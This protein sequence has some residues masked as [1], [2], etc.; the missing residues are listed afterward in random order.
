MTTTHYLLDGGNVIGEVEGDAATTYLRGVN[1]I[2]SGGT[3]YLYNAHGDVVQ[4][5]NTNG[6]LTRNYNYDAFGNERDPDEDDINPFRYCGEYYDTE[7]GLYYLRARYYDPLIGRFTQEDTHWNTANMI[8]GDNP[9]KI[10]EREDALGLKCYS[11]APQLL[12]IL[13]AGNLYVYTA[14]NPVRYADPSGALIWPGEIHQAVVTYIVNNYEGYNF[15]TEQWIQYSIP[16]TKNGK[17]YL[18]GRADI[19]SVNNSE[20]K[21]WE[22]KPDK[23]IYLILGAIQLSNYISGS[24][25]N[26]QDITLTEGDALNNA[27]FLYVD[28][29][30][31]MYWVK[32]RCCGGLILYTYEK[33]EGHPELKIVY[34]KRV[35]MSL[36]LGSAMF[37]AAAILGAESRKKQNAAQ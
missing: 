16:I 8:Y 7:T 22:V 29:T 32:F 30:G 15:Y 1:L 28:E 14:S 18:K 20:G 19:I 33:R 3:Y 35:A 27:E 24:L 2:S 17:V 26:F 25:V 21:V 34:S 37:V 31:T 12:S 6:E 11:Y 9:Q 13:Q 4:L 10:N 5:T 36:T 23:D